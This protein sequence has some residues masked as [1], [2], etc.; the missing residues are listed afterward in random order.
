[1]NKYAK[2]I[3][4]PKVDPESSI[5][6]K[7]GKKLEENDKKFYN[8]INHHPLIATLASGENKKSEI[9]SVTNLV[10]T[11]STGSVVAS[12]S[13]NGVNLNV[14]V[15]NTTT[16]SS[17]QNQ[18]SSGVTK[19]RSKTIGAPV[20]TNNSNNNNV[21]MK[22]KRIG[23]SGDGT[24]HMIRRNTNLESG[25]NNNINTRDNTTIPLT[26]NSNNN[27]SLNNRSINNAITSSPD[28]E[29]KANVVLPPISPNQ[30]HL[31]SLEQEHLKA[32]SVVE[33]I[34]KELHLL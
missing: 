7:I 32:M 25:S 19:K 9:E 34:K 2:K 8:N 11:L 4:K 1:M 23:S 27:S 29:N 18:N 24:Y 31:W 33:N 20:S 5:K 26:N 3:P 6:E 22:G 10:N 14:N 30:L 16:K 13:T 15:D 17:T 12:L 28:L 21:G